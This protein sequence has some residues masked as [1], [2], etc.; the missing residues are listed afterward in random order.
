MSKVLIVD[1]SEIVRR[2]IVDLLSNEELTLLQ[3][4]DGQDGL[5]KLREHPDT[6]LVLCDVNMPRLNGIEF[7]E[8]AKAEDAICSVPFVM[9]TTEGSVALI[10]QAKQAG[11]KGWIIKPFKEGVILS[12]TRRIIDRQTR[13][14]ATAQARATGS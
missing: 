4:V 3:A 10:R 12:V 7:L 9:V 5:E 14:A 2:Q 6:G 13:D 8:Q 1:D 11:A